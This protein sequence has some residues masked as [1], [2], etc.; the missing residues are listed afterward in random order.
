MRAVFTLIS[1]I[2]FLLLMGLVYGEEMIPDPSLTSG[3]RAWSPANALSYGHTNLRD[4]TTD[5]QLVGS[6]G[7]WEL[8]IVDLSNNYTNVKTDARSRLLYIV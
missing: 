8:I 5:D 2:S 7:Y 4:N 3:W 6:G 1:C